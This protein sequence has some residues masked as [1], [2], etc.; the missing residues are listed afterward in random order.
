MPSPFPGMDPYLESLWYDAHSRLIVYISTAL[1][2]VMPPHYIARLEERVAL[3]P[4]GARIRPDVSLLEQISVMPSRTAGGATVA[5]P[6]PEAADLPLELSPFPFYEEAPVESSIAVVSVR[7]RTR[8]ITAIE[9]LSPANKENGSG[10]AEYLRKQSQ[11]LRSSTHLV[12]MDFL[13]AGAPTIAPPRQRIR[14]R[15]GRTWE[16]AVSLHRGGQ[17]LEQFEVWP[18]SLRERLPRIRI[19]LESPDADVT[20]DLQAVFDQCY[21]DSGYGRSL[22]YSQDA[23]PLLEGD[24]AAWADQRLRER[25]L[26][27]D[28]E[29]ENE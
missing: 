25:G 10:H 11:L 22:D 23:E 17:S 8:V 24:D 5:P 4:T 29:F 3:L 18:I 6:P 14:E 2:R 27:G 28:R 21:D 16:Y 13:R 12:E 9:L 7:E 20:L 15:H 26:R 1:N 19:P